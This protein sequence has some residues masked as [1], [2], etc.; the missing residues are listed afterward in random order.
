M[1]VRADGAT[2]GK[3]IGGDVERKDF[4]VPTSWSDRHR[5]LLY[6]YGAQSWKLSLEEERAEPFLAQRGAT[7]R[8]A[9][10]SP[11][12]SQVAYRSDESG[13][14]EIYV[15][16][17]PGPGGKWQVSTEGGA[18]P[19][20]S[21]SGGELYY[22]NRGRMMAVEVRTSPSFDAGAP[23]VLFESEFPESSPD[24]PARYGVAPDGR[25]LVV[26]PAPD[27]KGEER[28]EIHVIMNWLE[29]LPDKE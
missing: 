20:W 23:R 26:V 22:K 17:F 24:D 14:D 19:M 6:Q 12:G 11:D 5:T 13:R 3:E 25:F 15:V 18:Q 21:P 8:E 2:A 4:R 16:P 9:R 10:F 27:G 1:G 29:T 28:A 7:L